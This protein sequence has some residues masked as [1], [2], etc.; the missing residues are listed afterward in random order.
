MTMVCAVCKYLLRMMFSFPQNSA[1]HSTSPS[2]CMRSAKS[3]QTW[4]LQ[5][6][7]FLFK[8]VPHP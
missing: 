4:A 3:Y 2:S 5:L 1:N 7:K 8:I 6:P